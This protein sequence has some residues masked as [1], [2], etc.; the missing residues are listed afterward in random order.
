[1]IDLA[2][3]GLTYQG[4]MPWITLPIRDGLWL[5]HHQAGRVDPF[6][7]VAPPVD[8]ESTSGRQ[9]DVRDVAVGPRG[10]LAVI[11]PAS[12]DRVPFARPAAGP[13]GPSW[14]FLPLPQD[15]EAVTCA[16][17]FRDRLFVGGRSRS[18][19]RQRLGYF[20]LSE[21]SLR[22]HHLTMPDVIVERG[23][24]I[25]ALVIAGPRLLVIDA[26]FVPKLAILY[27]LDDGKHACH[28]HVRI[29]SGLNDEVVDAAAGR[30]YVAILTAAHHQQEGKAWKI[31][32]YERDTMVEVTTFFERAD[33]EDPLE[34]PT[35]L[36]F[37]DDILLMA[38]GHKGI[39]ALRLDDGKPTSFGHIPAIQPWK[40]AYFLPEVFSYILPLGNG[41]ITHVLQNEET[42]GI[43][44]VIKRGRKTWWE[45]VDLTTA[46]STRYP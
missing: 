31:G 43:F 11:P 39:G 2:A 6:H 7:A 5:C 27:R 3:P 15:M 33:W 36:T 13:D 21:E 1:M 14:H 18:D 40:Q 8:F 9:M 20:D 25:A 16:T 4:L 29:P 22:F 35:S 32:I 28:D 19:D 44:A 34:P 12:H 17:F 45:H 42:P 30:R 41:R 23:K 37:V 38:H 24:P 10:E 26:A 46:R